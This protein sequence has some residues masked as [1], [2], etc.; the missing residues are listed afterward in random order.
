MW[1][2]KRFFCLILIFS[3][4]CLSSCSEGRVPPREAIGALLA[5]HELPSGVVY[6]D[7]AGDDT[8]A[9][10]ML[11]QMLGECEQELE[12]AEAFALYLSARETVCEVAVF[13]CYTKGEARELAAL[14]LARG[15]FL[16]QHGKGVTSK[17]LVKG[18]Y[19]LWVASEDPDTLIATL[20]RA[21]R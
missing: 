17:V 5:A 12:G 11:F 16:M 3:C 15:E 20:S 6:A 19:L 21:V 13:D 2:F 10:A 18:R 14:C 9:R 8:A 1:A 7:E 4:S